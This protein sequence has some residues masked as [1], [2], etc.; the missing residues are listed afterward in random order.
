MNNNKGGQQPDDEEN[1][2]LKSE[3]EIELEA[4]AKED[5]DEAVHLILPIVTDENKF[6]DADDAVHKIITPPT[7][8]ED[9]EKQTDP[10]ELA[11]GQ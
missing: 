11:H 1:L 10:D 8:E 4:L 2:P 9:L 3:E 6:E 7:F 5:P